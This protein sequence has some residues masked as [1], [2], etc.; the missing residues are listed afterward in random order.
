MYIF[1]NNA[2]ESGLG[3][4]L[5]FET[6]SQDLSLETDQDPGLECSRNPGRWYRNQ[7]TV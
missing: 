1:R 4:R 3:L 6:S 7:K 2:I 5:G